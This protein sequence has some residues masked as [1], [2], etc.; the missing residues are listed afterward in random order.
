MPDA[1][2]PTAALPGYEPGRDVLLDARNLKGLAHPIRLRLRGAL[3]EG[4]PATATQL[5]ARIGESSG[6]TSYHLRQLAAYGF[7][8]EDPSL[9]KGRERY[10]RAVHF[11]TW[12]EGPAAPGDREV[13][14]EYLRAVAHTYAER[15]V[16]FANS[17]DAVDETL[18]QE[19]ANAWNMSD[20]LLDLTPAQAEQLARGFH[21]L[22]AP[23]R[24]DAD[25]DAA[26]PA[27]RVAHVQFQILP[28]PL[29]T[30][31]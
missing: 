3:V 22:C 26:P 19:W 23:Y 31:S 12:Y 16:R 30:P 1:S 27:T 28:A 24:H 14:A 20:W 10:W 5:A 4:G 21:E 9:G 18:G 6:S 11:G 29:D 15:V 2:G 25:A 7:V 8:E 13:E 17:V